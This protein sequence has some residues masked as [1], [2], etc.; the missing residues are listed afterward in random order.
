LGD[1]PHYYITRRFSSLQFHLL[2]FAGVLTG[3]GT[4]DDLT[5]ADLIV[6]DISRV[7]DL[8]TPP[9]EEARGRE[10]HSVQVRVVGYTQHGIRISE[11]QYTLFA[12]VGTGSIAFPASY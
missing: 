3:V 9:E 8:V 6:E 10:W 5:H 7:V 1:F 2:T 4:E 11:D 12:A